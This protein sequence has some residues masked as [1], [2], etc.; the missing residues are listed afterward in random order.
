LREVGKKRGVETG[1]FMG[2]VN[3]AYMG[4]PGKLR[5]HPKSK[6]VKRLKVYS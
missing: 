3:T 6:T 2:M 5:G 1:L 4:T